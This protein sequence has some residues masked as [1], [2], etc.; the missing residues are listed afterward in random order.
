MAGMSCRCGEPVLYVNPDGEPVCRTHY[1][2]VAATA[3]PMSWHEAKGL[4]G[5]QLLWERSLRDLDAKVKGRHE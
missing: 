2:P 5:K 3:R 1:E 4:L